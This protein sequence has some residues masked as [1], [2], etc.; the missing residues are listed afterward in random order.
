MDK[1]KST[2]IAIISIIGV[3]VL[4]III[5]M[6]INYSKDEKSLSILEKKWVTNNTNN[7]INVNVFNDVPVYGYNGDGIIFDFLSKFT[8]EYNVNFNKISYF[9]S[10]KIEYGDIAFKVLEPYSKLSDNDILFYEDNYV[11]LSKDDNV[12]KDIK[13]LV[14][15]NVGVLDSDKELVTN[16][17]SNSETVIGFKNANMLMEGIKNDTVKYVIVPNMLFMDRI[18]ANEL[19]VVY[20]LSDLDKKYVLYAKDNTVYSIFS[21]FYASFLENY[22]VNSISRNYLNVYFE[23]TNTSSLEQKNYNSKIYKYGYIVNMPYENFVDGNFVG[24]FSNYLKKFEEMTNMEIN[25]VK[26]KSINDIKNALVSGDIDFALANFD[27]DSINLD[28]YLTISF[29]KEDY[30]V[31][32]R[33]NINVNSINGLKNYDVS[34]IGSSNLYNLCVSN[35]FNPK[36]FN[37]SDELLRSID[38]NSVILMD[39]NTYVYYKDAK[40][41]KFKVVL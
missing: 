9:S 41:K 8:E 6:F 31:L 29:M 17:L 37:D 33:N 26:Y 32:S 10:D 27:Y 39:K 40:L 24:V 25:V 16:Y 13:S 1:K 12:I 22:Y 23:G 35:G 30:V 14:S 20:H 19:N 21:K 34:V 11:V 4:G 7:I 38:Y 5:F 18:L 15:E 2:K 36:M 3:I 28:K